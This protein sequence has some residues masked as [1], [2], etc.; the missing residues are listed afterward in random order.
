MI[1]F[2]NIEK[3]TMQL[4]KSHLKPKILIRVNKFL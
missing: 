2:K 1:E 3:N 4:T